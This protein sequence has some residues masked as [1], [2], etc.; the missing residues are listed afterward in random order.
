MSLTEF[1]CKAVMRSWKNNIRS[2]CDLYNTDSLMHEPI[3]V[4]EYFEEEREQILKANNMPSYESQ[5]SKEILDGALNQ[6]GK[7]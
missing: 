3:E 5:V 7:Y 4:S 6:Y 1:S 2:V